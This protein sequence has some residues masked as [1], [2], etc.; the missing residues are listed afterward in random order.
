MFVLLHH[1]HIHFYLHAMLVLIIDHI[2]FI[3]IKD[4]VVIYQHLMEIT[5]N[6]RQK[7]IDGII[8]H[9]GKLVSW[10]HQI[11]SLNKLL[12]GRSRT[13]SPVTTKSGGRKTIRKKRKKTK[14]RVKKRKKTRGRKK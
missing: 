2:Y 10:L 1:Q 8:S 13:P 6:F 4:H 12:T 9:D 3:G 11:T 14:K 5:H 7:R